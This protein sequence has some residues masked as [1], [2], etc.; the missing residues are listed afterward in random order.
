MEH[1]NNIKVNVEFL[2][3]RGVEN[4]E[5][6]VEC[7]REVYHVYINEEW[8]YTGNWQHDRFHILMNGGVVRMNKRIKID[9]TAEQ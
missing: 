4:G 5:L 9:L 7:K 8:H 6:K 1:V 3:N 2:N